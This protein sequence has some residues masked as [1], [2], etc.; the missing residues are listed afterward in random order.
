MLWTRDVDRAAAFYEQLVGWTTQEVVGTPGH[1]LLQFGSKTVGN[2]QQ[3]ARGRDMWVPHVSVSSV[4]RTT[5]DALILGATL[6]DTVD[7][8][9]LARLATLRDREGAQFGLWEPAPHQGSPLT[10]E[11]GS[12]WWVEVLSNDVGGARD[13]YGRLFGWTS[14]ETAFEPFAAYT[15]FKRGDVQEGGIL[16]IGRDWGVSPR[17]N[18]IFAVSDCDVTI[19]RATTLGGSTILVHT[20]PKHG[21]IGSFCDSGGA[22]FAIRGPVT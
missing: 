13:F 11:V 14:I 15:V 20:V 6:E 1:R 22:T 17:W 18:A 8:P 5:A 9:G 7:V 21:R 10:D 12:L 3:I 19:E 4:E 16:P 2:L